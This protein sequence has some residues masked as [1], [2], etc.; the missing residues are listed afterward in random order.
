[1]RRLACHRLPA[2]AVLVVAGLVTGIGEWSAYAVGPKVGASKQAKPLSTS[3]MWL[4]L[5]HFSGEALLHSAVAFSNRTGLVKSR[6]EWRR[7][8]L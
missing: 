5:P 3:I 2:T 1:M 8:G 6:A 4:D 7:T